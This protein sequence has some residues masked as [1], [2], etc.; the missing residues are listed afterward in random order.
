[1]YRFEGRSYDLVRCRCGLVFVDPMPGGPALGRMYDDPAYYTDGYNLGVETENYFERRDELLELYDGAVARL[2]RETGRRAGRLLE[3][4]SAGGFLLE[5][6]RRRGWEVRGV[7]LSAP[8][9]DYCRRTF[10]L[11]VHRG[12]LRDAPFPRG[13]FDVVVADN[14][15]EH[16]PEPRALLAELT[17]FL[18]PGGHLLVVVPSYVNSPFFRAFL[19]VHRLLPAW[20]LG[21]HLMRLLKFDGADA[22]PPYHVLELDRRTLR[23][24][25]DAAEL[26]R[27]D[28]EGSV[29][30]PAHLFKRPAR[31]LRVALLRTV[32][33][34]L[35]LG[36]RQGLVPPVRLRVLARRPRSPFAPRG[37]LV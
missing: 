16:T 21:R 12:D 26:R 13:S 17:S 36:M 25:L 8:A 29:P 6:A 37:E 23:R 3:L 35:D 24:A 14:V 11:A 30:L 9:V 28:E 33:R 34:G 32:F 4:G 1:M 15:L 5:A 20:V 7:E 31:G 19:L 27:V 18:R 22:G 2:E 10:G